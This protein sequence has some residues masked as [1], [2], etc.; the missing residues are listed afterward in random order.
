MGHRFVIPTGYSSGAQTTGRDG[1][2]R[3]QSPQEYFL[4]FF[5]AARQ[6]T[7]P[8]NSKGNSL[9]NAAG[10]GWAKGARK[11]QQIEFKTMARNQGTSEKK[12]INIENG[13]GSTIHLTIA[14]IKLL[15]NVCGIPFR[16]PR[17]LLVRG[18]DYI[19]GWRAL[20]QSP[21]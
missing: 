17:M 4:E 15:N 5:F 19:L 9:G 20:R 11:T 21:Q 14:S 8:Q 7:L 16:H 3:R 13:V 10:T 12:T 6:P 18:A 1:C 2:A